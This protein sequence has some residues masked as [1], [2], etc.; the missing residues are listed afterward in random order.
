MSSDDQFEK[1]Y[2]DLCIFIAIWDISSAPSTP[3]IIK[4]FLKTNIDEVIA[5]FRRSETASLPFQGSFMSTTSET[6]QETKIGDVSAEPVDPE[7]RE[8]STFRGSEVASNGSLSDDHLDGGETEDGDDEE[9]RPSTLVDVGS[10]DDLQSSAALAA[11]SRKSRHR[12]KSSATLSGDPPLF[13]ARGTF[14]QESQTSVSSLALTEDIK[15]RLVLSARDIQ[16]HE[17]NPKLFIKEVHGRVSSDKRR[18]VALML[19][20]LFLGG[21]HYPNMNPLINITW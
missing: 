18:T 9:W 16:N 20:A 13:A 15:S 12:R 19:K 3:P 1:C 7:S 2:P 14:R 6:P 10:S 8:S 4:L 21:Y 11:P 17:H 5:S